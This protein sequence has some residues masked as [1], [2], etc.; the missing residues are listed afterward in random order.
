MTGGNTMLLYGD[1][2]K[3]ALEQETLPILK[4]VVD[5]ALTARFGE[6]W[7]MY[8]ARAIMEGYGDFKKVDNFVLGEKGKAIDAFDIAAIC[9][10]VMPYDKDLKM[11]LDGAM[12]MIEEKYGLEA[13]PERLKRLRTIYG[14]VYRN[15][16]DLDMQEDEQTA[17]AGVQE[18][19]W[20]L[21][22]EKTLKEIKPEFTLETYLNQLDEVVSGNMA[23]VQKQEEE[24]AKRPNH[25]QVRDAYTPI[26]KF[27]FSDAP[28]GS[29]MVGAAPWSVLNADLASLPW[30]S[31][32]GKDPVPQKPAAGPGAM[33]GQMPGQ[34]PGMPRPAA[35]SAKP[36]DA[37]QVIAQ[38]VVPGGLNLD[39][40]VKP[41]SAKENAKVIPG[42]APNVE[43]VSEEASVEE[44][45]AEES[46]AE[47]KGKNKLFGWFK[48]K[49]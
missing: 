10:L 27:E 47:Q 19:T 20:L 22:I 21:D 16:L 25:Q 48:G 3:K 14:N 31:V 18:K 2:V 11:Y 12:P 1:I 44:T 33:P 34:M 30:P 15:K 37:A 7:Y 23:K 45:V 5:T 4:E 39:E 26:K 43:A 29:P 38:A 8:F 6:E 35:A 42:T 40:F 36:M 41:D 13:N 17:I 28:I 32:S 24:L 46:E 9:Y 49:K